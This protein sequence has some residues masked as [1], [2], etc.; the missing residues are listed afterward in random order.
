M[1][2]PSSITDQGNLAG[3]ISDDPLSCGISSGSFLI[4]TRP[5]SEDGI[6]EDFVVCAYSPQTGLSYLG[7]ADSIAS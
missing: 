6:G 4:V 3:Q 2:P 7:K 1:E 5:V